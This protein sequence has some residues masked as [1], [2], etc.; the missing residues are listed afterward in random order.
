MQDSFTLYLSAR[1][2]FNGILSDTAKSI[3][4][5]RQPTKKKEE[6]GFPH[7]DNEFYVNRTSYRYRN[8]CNFSINAIADVERG[9]EQSENHRLRK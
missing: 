8:Y 4:F 3:G 2:C 5:S 6:P 1:A 7:E 9:K